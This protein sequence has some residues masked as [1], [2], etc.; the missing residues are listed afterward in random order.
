MHKLSRKDLNFAELESVR[1]SSSPTKVVT[2][3]GEVRAKEEEEA[4]VCMSKNSIYS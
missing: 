2:A 1:V 3:N 4:T